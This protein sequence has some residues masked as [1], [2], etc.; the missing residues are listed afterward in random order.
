MV[1]LIDLPSEILREICHHVCLILPSDVVSK[2][3][4]PTNDLDSS[5]QNR[6]A[7]IS[8]YSNSKVLTNSF[9]GGLSALHNCSEQTIYEVYKVYDAVIRNRCPR[10]SLLALNLTCKRLHAIVEPLL[11]TLVETYRESTN[12]IG[13][14][15]KILHT[16]TKRPELRRHIKALAFRH[17]T[18]YPEHE[19]SFSAVEKVEMSA[20]LQHDCTHQVASLFDLLPNLRSLKLRIESEP[21]YFSV[22][23]PSILYPSGFP[24]ALQNLTEFSLHWE[25]PDA[26]AFWAPMLLPLFLL[27]SLKTL[28]LGHPMASLPSGE[29]SDITRYQHTSSI[30]TLIIHFGMVDKK[31]IT[32]FCK[33]PKALENFSYSYGGGS[34]RCGNADVG[35]YC[36]ALLPQKSSLKTLNI[37]GCRD[38]QYN[39]DECAP[40]PAILRSFTAV[41]EFSC[42]V[43]LLLF[44]Q[45]G[46]GPGNYKLAEVLPP[47]VEKVTLFVYDDWT[48]DKMAEEL[49]DFFSFGKRRFETLREV[50]VEI[51]LKEEDYVLHVHRGGSHDEALSVIRSRVES[52]K[53]RGRDKGVRLEVELDTESKTEMY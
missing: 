14:L 8:T 13:D 1:K 38:L 17:F 33:L 49:K 53:I 20:L 6:L 40:D 36:S 52:L 47:N 50:M 39:Q 28:F 3:S 21:D 51:W 19:P 10:K 25:N 18:I 24:L 45:R 46:G 48:F 32:A 5:M 41:T 26:D 9:S 4:I 37:R 16:V 11:W 7:L 43:R 22:F 15:V 42:P 34:N 12:S 23:Q 29:L 30:T 27:P 44:R 31:V 35:E 2:Y